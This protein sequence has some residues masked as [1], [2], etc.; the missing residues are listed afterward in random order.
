MSREEFNLSDRKRDILLTAIESY[1]DKA[2]PI[3]SGSVQENAFQT[4]SSATLRNELN[5]L[6]A[7]GYLKQL[8]TSGGRI[9][10]SKAYRLYVDNLM[11]DSTSLD[12]EVIDKIKAKFSTRSAYLKDVLDNLAESI[13]EVTSYPTFV[14]LKGYQE[15]VVQGINIIPLI[16]GQ[17]LI[18]FQTNA[19]IISNT[20]ALHPSITEENCKDA[21]KFLSNQL[22]G[23]KIG[24]IIEHY[25]DYNQSFHNQIGYFEELFNSITDVL[26]EYVTG[27]LSFVK[28][29]STTKLLSNPE[30]SDIDNAKKFL[31]IVENEDRIQEIISSIDN[32]NSS[33]VVITIGEE[34]VNEDL[35]HYSIVQANYTMGNG[36]VTNISVLGPERMD[37]PKITS[38][39]KF[40]MD[41]LKS[42]DKGEKE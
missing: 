9:P 5:A 20:L 42:M 17:A 27:G 29:T 39:L 4:L 28:N 13:N 2:L 1:I 22:Y 12:S 30:Y 25:D 19:G 23:K 37:Y 7:M 35:S 40:I 38:A 11:A 32:N 6:E 10:T 34:N 41:E 14:T 31:N 18:L 8:H 33:D 26:K 16:T 24:E 21:S 3:T 36:V 15:L